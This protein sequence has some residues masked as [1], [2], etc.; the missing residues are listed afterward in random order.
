M[1]AQSLTHVTT[2]PYAS[3]SAHCNKAGRNVWLVMCV[4]RAHSPMTRPSTQEACGMEGGGV[5]G[6]LDGLGP[7]GCR[8]CQAPCCRRRR[9]PIPPPHRPP[10]QKNESDETER[11]RDKTHQS[12]PTYRHHI[13]YRPGLR[14]HGDWWVLSLPRSVLC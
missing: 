12:S 14:S 8:T 3:S 13:I 11:G 5:V 9:S 2:T 10:P 7:C 1:W 4:A 6:V